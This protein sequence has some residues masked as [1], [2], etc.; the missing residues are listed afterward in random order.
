MDACTLKGWSPPA[1]LVRLKPSG[2]NATE[3]LAHNIAE[4]SPGS[5]TLFDV[6]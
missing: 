1:A 5:K 3:V 4:A 6:R 2:A